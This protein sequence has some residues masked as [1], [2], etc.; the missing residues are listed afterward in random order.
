MTAPERIFAWSKETTD[1]DNRPVTETGWED[2]DYDAKWYADRGT[3]LSSYTRTDL[4]QP[5]IDK[6]VAEAN[7]R[8]DLA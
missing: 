5:M 3:P 6:A 4:I 1:R 7:A 8:A 2:D